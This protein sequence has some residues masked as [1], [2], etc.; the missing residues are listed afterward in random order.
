MQ[1][2]HNDLSVSISKLTLWKYCIN[3]KLGDAVFN[4][5]IGKSKIHFQVFN[6]KYN[7]LYAL[8]MCLCPGWRLGLHSSFR[9]WGWTFLPGEGHSQ[10]RALFHRRGLRRRRECM[11]T[12]LTI[13]NVKT[14][15]DYSEKKPWKYSIYI[16]MYVSDLHWLK[17]L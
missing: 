15:T 17:E 12:L 7:P 9:F 16:L 14:R 5:V 1:S 13:N 10:S 11:S 2:F 3:M 4:P 8:F 6:L